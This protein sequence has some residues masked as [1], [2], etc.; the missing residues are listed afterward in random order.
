[1]PLYEPIM[2]ARYVE[3][4][5]ALL[6][7]AQVPL[8]ALDYQGEADPQHWDNE[9]TMQQFDSLLST[10]ATWLGR[11]DL[12]FELGLHIDIDSHDSL[13]LALRSCS[14]LDQMLR[15]LS[16]YWRLVTTCFFLRYQRTESVGI[17]TYRPAA[18]MSQGTLYAMQETF[19][20]AFHAD[21][22]ALLGTAQGIDTYL[23]IPPPAHSRRYRA[24]RPTRF[25]F[26]AHALPEVRCILP[27]ALLDRPLRQPPPAATAPSP[28]ELALGAQQPR[29][30]YRDWI[31][32]MLREAEGLQPSREA[33][34]EL[35]NISPR[36]LTR[37]LGAEGCDLREL[38]RQIRH[39]R[40]CQMLCESQQPVAQIAYRL[41]YR[42]PTN[43]TSAFRK[44]S[45]MTPREFRQ[46]AR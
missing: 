5:L 32:M 6:R 45:G 24:L 7:T 29:H 23:S 14:T 28:P 33:L 36:T 39:Q 25:H 15:L 3:P 38:G 16:R 43:F 8:Q 18:G 2:P 20:V 21:Y 44:E 22:T 10:S 1:M 41:G 34:A 35:L 27:L 11:S 17:L 19:A 30:Q 4:L 9:L 13:S 31:S 40:A 26:S 12:G 46:Q 37:H 42:E